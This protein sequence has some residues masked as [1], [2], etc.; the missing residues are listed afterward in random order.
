[1]SQATTDAALS[2]T[3]AAVAETPQVRG[4]AAPS[5]REARSSNQGLFPFSLCFMLLSAINLAFHDP[6]VTEPEA[7]QM[8][9]PCS[10][11][12]GYI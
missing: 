5:E 3:E 1:M 12:A 2:S 10:Q 11:S 7:G 4:P 8:F 6:Q 9:V